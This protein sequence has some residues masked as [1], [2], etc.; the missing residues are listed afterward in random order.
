[1]LYTKIQGF[2][3]AEISRFST[4]SLITRST[5]DIQQVQMLITMGLQMAI[6]APVTAVWAIVKI[7]GKE[8]QWSCAVALAV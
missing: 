1:M 3:M 8:W 4:A 2:S 7:S 5:N 6:K